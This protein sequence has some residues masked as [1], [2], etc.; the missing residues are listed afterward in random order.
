MTGMV[1]IITAQA[2]MIIL[3]D[4]EVGTAGLSVVGL[5]PHYGPTAEQLPVAPLFL[6]LKNAATRPDFCN[7]IM[8]PTAN[9]E[10]WNIEEFDYGPTCID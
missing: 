5:G 10:F 9:S 2:P 6:R 7:F 3:L 4:L 8:D 1:P